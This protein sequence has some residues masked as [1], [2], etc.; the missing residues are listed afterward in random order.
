MVPYVVDKNTV[1]WSGFFKTDEEAQKH[2]NEMTAKLSLK[3]DIVSAKKELQLR[4][5]NELAHKLK[6]MQKSA[7]K[8][9]LLYKFTI[10]LTI[11]E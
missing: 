8:D 6:E 7:A 5:N 10:I 2:L 9:L 1:K 3:K 4:K 11:K